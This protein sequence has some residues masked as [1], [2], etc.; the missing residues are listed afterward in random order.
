M[1]L[2]G[3]KLTGGRV[4]ANGQDVRVE[5][6]VMDMRRQALLSGAAGQAV[7]LGKERDGDVARKCSKCRFSGDIVIEAH[8]VK[9][10]GHAIR[11][12]RECANRAPGD[13]LILTI[14][15]VN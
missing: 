7:L 11:I 15:L 14:E 8:F 6:P 9:E 1:R 4:L 12:C 13:P 5:A 3:I 2:G 10:D